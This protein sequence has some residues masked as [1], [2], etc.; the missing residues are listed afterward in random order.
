MPIPYSELQFPN[1]DMSGRTGHLFVAGVELGQYGYGNY[2]LTVSTAGVLDIPMSSF[3][4]LGLQTF[5]NGVSVMTMAETGYYEGDA[6]VFVNWGG[7]TTSPDQRLSWY[8]L[9]SRAEMSGER[10]HILF[11]ELFTR[12]LFSVSRVQALSRLSRNWPRE[13]VVREPVSVSYIDSEVLAPIGFLSA[14]KFFS[15][16]LAAKNSNRSI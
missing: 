15:S 1:Y 10:S 7:I 2:N 9:R 14:I 5:R 4:V 3:K 13:V 12:V 16:C 11:E 6:G 8:P